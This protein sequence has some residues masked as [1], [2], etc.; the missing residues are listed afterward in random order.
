MKK[1]KVDNPGA[2]F[3]QEKQKD[4]KVKLQSFEEYAQ[5]Q[6]PTGKDAN[7]AD[8]FKELKAFLKGQKK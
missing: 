3:R 8:T 2:T 4:G 6:D 7:K 1:L 5:T